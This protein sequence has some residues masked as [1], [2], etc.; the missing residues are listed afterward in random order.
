M[1]SVRKIILKSVRKR[2]EYEYENINQTLMVRLCFEQIVD[3]LVRNHN[4]KI[5]EAN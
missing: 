4:Q 3:I 5:L 2:I 1:K